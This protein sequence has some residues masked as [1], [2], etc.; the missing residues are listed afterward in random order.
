MHTPTDE[1]YDRG[2]EWWLMKEAQRRNPGL[3]LYGLPWTFPGWVTTSGKGGTTTN[4]DL[5]AIA[6]V[7][8]E[9]TA[10]YV[11]R[12]VDGAQTHHNLT[13]AFLGL[14]NEH[15][16]TPDYALYLRAALDRSVSGKATQL[17]G[18]DWHFSAGPLVPFLT[19][20]VSNASVRAAIS[21]VGFHYPKRGRW[22]VPSLMEGVT[23]P[24]WSSEES[25]TIDTPAG[26]ACWARLLSQ[27]YVVGKLTASIMWNLVTSFYTSLPY[28]G[29][30]LMNAAEPWSGHYEVSLS[31]CCCTFNLD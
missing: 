17:V 1:A 5:G 22:S 19:A 14:W 20:L 26:G 25:S 31:P 28:Y 15:P 6:E 9:K 23:Q 3:V 11:A 30:S 7:L 13:I 18:P 10:D 4:Q 27:N 24:V 2:Y 8:T 12:W 21:R 29:A 16:P